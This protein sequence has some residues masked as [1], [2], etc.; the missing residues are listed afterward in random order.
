MSKTNHCFNLVNG[1]S[2]DL[3]SPLHAILGFT[4]LVKTELLTLNKLPEKSLK[5]LDIV[6]SI[7][8]DMLD[9]IN[10]MLT[11]ARLQSG[12]QNIEPLFITHDVCLSLMSDLEETFKAEMISR[13]I[14]FSISYGKLPELIYWD[15]KSLRYFVMNNLISNALKFV[16]KDGTVHVHMESDENNMVSVSVADNGPG[17]PL[18]DREKIF[19][20]FAQASNNMQSNNGSGFGLFNANE[21]VKTHRGRITISDGL[22]NKGVTFT[23]TIP[24]IPFDNDIALN[25]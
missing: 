18:A 20:R 16:N 1:V 7:G 9:L 11:A 19:E 23:V 8:H 13:N 15:V 3:K 12:Q 22:N 17:I 6:S 10:N 24:A 21:T 2:H 5:H 25:G 4:E 14:E